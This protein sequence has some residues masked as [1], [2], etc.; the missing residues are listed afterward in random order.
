MSRD[1]AEPFP[2]LDESPAADVST[3]LAA[4]RLAQQT[5]AT[6]NSL[7]PGMAPATASVQLNFVGPPALLAEVQRLQHALQTERNQNQ[8]L[9]NMLLSASADSTS[10]KAS[11]LDME[12][13]HNE[14]VQEF[15]AAV[16]QYKS[17]LA[18]AYRLFHSAKTEIRDLEQRV[19]KLIEGMFMHFFF[20][21]A[22]LFATII[23]FKKFSF[24]DTQKTTSC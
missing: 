7:A 18:D 15:E 21:P 13:Q 2:S 16:K 23:R 12:R 3:A 24:V 6:N 19:N 10:L 9:S 4:T 22:N 5:T 20:L 14:K 17:Q 1:T 8:L 11:L